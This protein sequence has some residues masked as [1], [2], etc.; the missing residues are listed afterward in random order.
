MRK[1]IQLEDREYENL[2]ELAQFNEQQIEEKAIKLWKEK[3]VAEIRITIDSGRDY[4]DV[5]SITASSYVMYKD[6][7][8][9]IPETL[10]S[11]FRE[12][13]SEA[14]N[15]Y[16]PKKFGNITQII[17]NYNGR[18]SSLNRFKFTMMAIAASGWAAAAALFVLG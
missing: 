8:F 6:S 4:D 16:I 2:V 18:V 5:Y 9:H 11:R 10:R 15:D 3:G 13:I 7:K 14:V 12:I 1:I 17:N